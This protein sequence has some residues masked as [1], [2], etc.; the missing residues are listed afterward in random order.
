M[1][2][3]QSDISYRL[4][5]GAAN[6]DPNASLGGA[7]SDVEITDGALHN[8]FDP[9]SGQESNA[10]DVEYR[11][12]Y[13]LNNHGTLTWQQVQTWI[14]SQTTSTDT[15][16]SI[17]LDAAGIGDGSSTGVAATIADESTAPAGVTFTQPTSGSP[18]AIGD[19]PPGE[20]IAVWVRRTVNAGA[21]AFNDDTAQ[22]RAE[23]DTA[24]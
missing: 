1:P 23:G 15:Q 16:I 14:A 19:I 21:A 4:S 10:G 9:V 3:A 5:G 8:L 17:G 2:I 6:S 11:C 24:A 13:I 12:L 22:L 7:M 18:I 20:A